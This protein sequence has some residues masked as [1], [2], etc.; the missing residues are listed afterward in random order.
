MRYLALAADYDNTLARDGHIAD[1]TAAALERLR[2]S[3]CRL[4]LVTGRCLG[5]LS[6]I[7][8]RLPIFDYV[9][10]EN[11]A[12]AFDP[13]THAI[14]PLFTPLP[15]RLLDRLK[16]YGVTPLE[17]GEIIIATLE[18]QKV[19]VLKVIQELKLEHHLQLIF[20]RKALMI[21]PLGTNKAAGLEFVLRKLSLPLHR[22]IG[23]GDAENDH[24]FLERCGCAIAVAN[25]VPSIR[26]M[27]TLV[28]QAENGK[29]VVEIAQRLLSHDENIDLALY[30][31]NT[32]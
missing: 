12:L 30:S 2:A 18:N 31:L 17:V 6:W 22:V 27:A 1:T 3:G 7:Q 19:A 25:A 32:H 4:I 15:Q 28:T 13:Q 11:G 24:S 26:E 5:D 21:L 29:G 16:D 10:A 8:R 14:M 20:N 9:V 23:I